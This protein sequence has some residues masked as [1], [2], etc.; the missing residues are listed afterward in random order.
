MQLELKEHDTVILKVSFV[1]SPIRVRLI[2]AESNGIWIK[3]HDLLGTLNV[4]T[5]DVAD[6][7]KAENSGALKP[8]MFIPFPQVHYVLK[9]VP[10]S[11]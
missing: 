10:A 3:A 9:D 6:T 7:D 4:L 2:A 5:T 11:S 8:M 1:D